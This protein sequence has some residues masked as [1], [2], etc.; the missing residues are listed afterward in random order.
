MLISIIPDDIHQILP[1]VVPGKSN[2][3]REVLAQELTTATDSNKTVTDTDITTGTGTTATATDGMTSGTDE[4]T[5]RIDEITSGAED[6]TS[7]TDEVTDEVTSRTDGATSRTDETSLGTDD[8]TTSETDEVTQETD[9]TTSGTEKSTSGSL[10]EQIFCFYQLWRAFLRG[11]RSPPKRPPLPTNLIA[12]ILRLGDCCVPIP[13][14]SRSAATGCCV[15]SQGFNDRLND[16]WFHT[17]PVQPSILPVLRSSVA[18]LEIDILSRDQGWASDPTA[19]CSWF[20]LVLP[21]RPLTDENI[22]LNN[23]RTIVEDG[24]VKRLVWVFHHN[25]IASPHWKK[26]HSVI[27]E[28]HEVWKYVE[29]G[30]VLGVRV[31]AQYR[32]WE[33]RA[34]DGSMK[35]MR[36]FEPG[37][38][39]D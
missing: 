10:T 37:V 18:R 28:N 8:T 15:I 31:C 30:D 22:G 19:S 5:S 25:D 17:L 24:E 34:R 4:K 14:L 39:D 29:A 2:C 6:T 38:V 13:S 32:G 3:G 16:M 33:N 21:E 36:Y 27:D 12:E 9:E 20:E 26:S 35:V 23:P 1:P 11:S 7:R